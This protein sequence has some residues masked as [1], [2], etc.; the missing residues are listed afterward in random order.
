VIY[1]VIYLAPI[2]AAGLAVI[3][4]FWGKRYLPGEDQKLTMR[5]S[6]LS[7]G[8]IVPLLGVLLYFS[9]IG[10]L[11][12]FLLI[13]QLGV[14]YVQEFSVHVTSL[15]LPPLVGF[16]I[17]WMAFNNFFLLLIGLVAALRLI[18]NKIKMKTP[19]FAIRAA[20][21][22]W[23]LFSFIQAG[24]N[25]VGFAHYVLLIIPPLSFFAA[26]EINRTY[27]L[28]AE[29]SKRRK[30]M[31][32]AGGM[33]G[34]VLLNSIATNYKIYVQDLF[35]R[36]GEETYEQ[37]LSQRPGAGKL[38]LEIKPVAE[39]IQAHTNPNDLIYYWGIDAEL[40]YLA[41]RHASIE[42]IWPYYAAASPTL[43]NIFAPATKYIIL[44]DAESQ[45]RPDWL[46]DGIRQNYH[47]EITIQGREIYRRESTLKSP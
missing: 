29:N 27:L 37:S 41:D 3:F 13:F 2:A 42:F 47:Y 28:V 22:F 17:F 36:L 24:V 21:L 1:K 23:L 26:L 45:R 9:S 40:Y 31:V 38:Y 32:L 5:I 16:P 30:A 18:R 46:M 4:D 34:L 12:R 10:L 20:L 15:P 19:D 43:A 11:D 35:Y 7:A 8:F 33:V 6:W 44:A 25:R 14:K 39:Y